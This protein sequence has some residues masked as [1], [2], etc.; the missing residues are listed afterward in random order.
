MAFC[1]FYCGIRP[2]HTG[3]PP[4]WIIEVILPAWAAQIR[5]CPW[6]SEAHYPTIWGLQAVPGAGSGTVTPCICSETSEKPYETLRLPRPWPGESFVE[7][8]L[9][10]QQTRRREMRPSDPGGRPVS[11][12]KEATW[13]EN[14]GVILSLPSISR[15]VA[16]MV[17]V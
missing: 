15:D 10:T 11:L 16:V 4:N 7:G 17:Q 6:A 2:V 8:P 13:V 14:N 12:D 1:T 5:R 3:V 9:A